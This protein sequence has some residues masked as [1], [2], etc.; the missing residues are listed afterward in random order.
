MGRS[1]PRHL[2]SKAWI[3]FSESA[4][5]VHVSQL[6]RRMEVTDLHD[7]AKTEEKKT[8]QNRKMKVIVVVET[9][10]IISALAGAKI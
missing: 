5:R 8:K 1:F 10:S 3:L 9:F 6:Q 4:S 7:H 2:V